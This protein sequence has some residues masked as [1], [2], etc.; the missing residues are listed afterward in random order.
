MT[1]TPSDLGALMAAFDASYWDEMTLTLTGE[2]V[3]L[4]KTGRPPANRAE[5]GE[6]AAG[7]GPVS[8]NPRLVPVGGARL[9]AATE[10]GAVGFPA[11]I[12]PVPAVEAAELSSETLLEHTTGIHRVTAPSVGVFWRAPDPAAPPFVELG[13]HVEPDTPICIVEVMKLFN[14]VQAGVRGTVRSIA[15]ENGDMVEHGQT[16]FLVELDG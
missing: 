7:P 5:A 11:E 14:H 2:T 10:A 6:P 9:P 1:L 13:S 16:L 15:V 12:A 3:L 8:R 4:T